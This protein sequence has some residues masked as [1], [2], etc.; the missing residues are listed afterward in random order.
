MIYHP[1]DTDERKHRL[2]TIAELSVG[3][4]L[5]FEC[6]SAWLQVANY[7][8]SGPGS[9]VFITVIN[10]ILTIILKHRSKEAR[11]YLPPMQKLPIAP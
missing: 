1:R 7:D 11:L 5:G 10:L 2:P 8:G 4:E 9:G 6:M 3:F